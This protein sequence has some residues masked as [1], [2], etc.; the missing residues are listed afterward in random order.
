MTT[1]NQNQIQNG[2]CGLCQWVDCKRAGFSLT[3]RTTPG[4]AMPV[5]VNL[6]RNQIKKCGYVSRRGPDA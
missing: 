5:T 1:Q 2:G 6:T 4:R 3:G